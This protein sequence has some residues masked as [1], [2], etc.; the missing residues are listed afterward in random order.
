MPTNE[1]MVFARPGSHL[2][3]PITGITLRT[4]DPPPPETGGTLYFMYS[5]DQHLQLKVV[6]ATLSNSLTTATPRVLAQSS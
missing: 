1:Q 4:S 6:F 3:S 2:F 5:T